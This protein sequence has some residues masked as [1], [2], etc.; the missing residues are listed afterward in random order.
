MNIRIRNYDEIASI[1]QK[2]WNIRLSRTRSDIKTAMIIISLQVQMRT[3]LQ[4]LDF[5]D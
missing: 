1:G 3:R 2:R 5:S 4:N